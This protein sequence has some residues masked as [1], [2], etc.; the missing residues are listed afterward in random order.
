MSDT[1][2]EVGERCWV[3][4]YPEWDVN[5]G[6]IAG[7]DGLLVIDTRG[8]LRQ[9]E[10][11]RDDV[12]QLGTAPVR[13]VANTHRHFEHTFGNRVFADQGSTIYAHEHTAAATRE[14]GER[15]KQQCRDSPEG[16]LDGVRS[17]QTLRDVV[18]TPLIAATETFAVA[19]VL[20]LGD[21]WVE[22]VHLGRGH[23]DGDVVAVVADVDVVFTGDLVEEAAHPSYGDDSFPLDWPDTTDRLAGLLGDGSRVVPGH[24][25]VVD[26]GF[27]LS[28][29]EE[30]GA[31][32]N[33]ISGLHHGGASLDDAL[34]HTADWPYPRAD[35]TNAV[36]RGYDQLSFRRPLP[37]A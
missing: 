29:G 17:A 7:S 15:V 2:S 19:K 11:L 9:G 26:R 13:W 22:L 18:D 23:T 32:A 6:V 1:W 36:R 4:R 8:T 33:T 30:L 12:R 24:G 21:R 16:D 31:V 35:L 25:A 5:V 34:A 14:H 3:R 10:E 20:D 37:L 27:V 28:Q